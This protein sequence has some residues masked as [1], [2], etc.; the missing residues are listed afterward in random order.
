MGV[1]ARDITAAKRRARSAYI[2]DDGDTTDDHIFAYVP[3]ECGVT[4]WHRPD[5]AERTYDKEHCWR[6]DD[7]AAVV[8]M[9]RSPYGWVVGGVGDTAE[10]SA[11]F[12]FNERKQAEAYLVNQMR[13]HE[14]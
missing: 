8:F 11:E 9:E 13:Q 12:G 14:A 10:I 6:R 7:K 4:G 5:D 2:T 3:D 1:T